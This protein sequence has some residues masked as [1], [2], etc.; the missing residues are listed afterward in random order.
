MKN[1]ALIG[2]AGYI[3]TRH[4]KAIKDTGNNLSVALDK[5]DSVGVMDSYF[6]EADLTATAF[7]ILSAP[8]SD[9]LSMLILIP[10]FKLFSPTINGSIFKYSLLKFFFERKPFA[11]GILPKD[12]NG[13]ILFFV[14]LHCIKY[15]LTI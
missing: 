15:F 11:I 13:L 8:A 4:M 3:A 7:T 6:P 9:G 12:M 14:I 10:I 2:A 5:F 1:F